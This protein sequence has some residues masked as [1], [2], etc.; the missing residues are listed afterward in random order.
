MS[1]EVLWLD[2]DIAYITPYKNALED[3]G[4]TITLVRS[5]GE[6]E[7]RLKSGSYRLVILDV[8]VPTKDQEEEKGYPPIETDYGHKTGIVFYLRRQNELNKAMSKVFVFTVRL[9]ESVK[10][11]FIAAGLPLSNFAT[12]FA[13]RDVTNFLKKVQAVVHEPGK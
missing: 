6:A 3:I 11:E 2:N 10:D 4:Y 8:M 13:L 7:F 5:V 9:D 1:K 12:K